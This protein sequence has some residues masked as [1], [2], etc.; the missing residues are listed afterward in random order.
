MPHANCAPASLDEHNARITPPRDSKLGDRLLFARENM[1][2]NQSHLAKKAGLPVDMQRLVIHLGTL[3]E[4]R[5][6]ALF[7]LLGVK[8]RQ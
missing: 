1:K 6:I 5:V 2:L 4:A 3:Y 8:R 7:V